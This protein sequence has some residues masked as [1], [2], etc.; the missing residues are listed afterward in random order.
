MESSCLS[1]D[2]APTVYQFSY[3]AVK[4]CK[5][6]RY[7]TS[8]TPARA[9][10][11]GF[12]LAFQR[13]SCFAMW[14]IVVVCNTNSRNAMKLVTDFFIVGHVCHGQENH[15]YLKSL[16]SCGSTCVGRLK[17]ACGP[18]RSTSLL[19]V[20]SSDQATPTC[21]GT[22]VPPT[23]NAESPPKSSKN[24]APNT[25]I[26]VYVRQDKLPRL[27]EYK[28]SGV[29]HSLLSQYVLKP[30]YNNVVIKCFPMW[31]A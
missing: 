4:D 6:A 26:M 2:I 8:C 11:N 12:K 3:E 17:P 5:R 22:I 10:I 31:M 9:C 1:A 15:V 14:I 19:V 27:K 18:R 21:F 25:F 13:S 29:D 23:Y 30:F 24:P 16:D 20:T 7:W 28:Y